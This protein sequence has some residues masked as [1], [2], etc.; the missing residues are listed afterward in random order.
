MAMDTTTDIKPGRYKLILSLLEDMLF[1][2][3][4][5]HQLVKLM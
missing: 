5:N 2:S 4:T 3:K 1:A